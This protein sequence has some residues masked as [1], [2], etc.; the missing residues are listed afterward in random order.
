MTYVTTVIG[1]EATFN[2]WADV[3]CC[4]AF[5]RFTAESSVFVAFSGRLAMHVEVNGSTWPTS[6]ALNQYCINV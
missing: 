1:T 5:L 4:A 3:E 6:V 2:N